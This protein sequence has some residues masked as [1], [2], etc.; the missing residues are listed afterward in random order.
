M[1]DATSLV[2]AVLP[3]P[4][5]RCEKVCLNIFEDNLNDRRKCLVR[6]AVRRRPVSE[7]LRA[8]TRNLAYLLA[9]LLMTDIMSEMLSLALTSLYCNKKAMTTDK[10]RSNLMFYYNVQF[11]QLRQQQ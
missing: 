1:H 11:T 2:T 9:Y 10:L 3:P 5:Q 6:L 8:P 4:G 7:R